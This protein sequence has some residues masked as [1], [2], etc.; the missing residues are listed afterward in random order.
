MVWRKSSAIV[1]FLKTLAGVVRSV[2]RELLDAR[3]GAHVT[4]ARAQR[5]AA[6][7]ARR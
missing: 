7:P 6:S 2:P 5:R 3:A 4:A 1:A